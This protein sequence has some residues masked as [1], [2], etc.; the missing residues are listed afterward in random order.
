MF[1]FFFLF[2]ISILPRVD[3]LDLVFVFGF[4]LLLLEALKR[5]TIVYNNIFA[6]MASLI[7]F[8]MPFSILSFLNYGDYFGFIRLLK[9]ILLFLIVPSAFLVVGENTTFKIMPLFLLIMILILYFEYFNIFGARSIVGGIND[10]LF[11]GRDVSFRAKGL[12]AGYSAAG[13]SC[14]FIAIFSFYFT[15]KRK[16]SSSVG[17][18]LFFL[19]FFAT[20]FTGRTGIFIAILGVLSF[21]IL[22]CHRVFSAKIIGIFGGV[23]LLIITVLFYYWDSLDFTVIEIT[24]IRTFEL[25]LN[26]QNHGDFSSESSTQL[27]KTFGL[28]SE[29]F[30]IFFGNGLKPW[31]ELSIHLGAHQTDSGLFQTVFLYGVF[32]FVIYYMPII[33]IYFC[34]FK[35]R[36]DNVYRNYVL[37]IIPLAFIAEVKGHYIY[38]SLIF[39]LLFLPV[40]FRRA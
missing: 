4:F 18:P 7:L 17:W 40:F 2:S 30:D 15:L 24:F 37:I 21:S 39:V 27:A 19:A 11:V 3:Q 5:R 38:S 14:G 33:Y 31:S 25:F 22:E 28:P 13:V 23:I 26:Y 9:L 36:K 10:L 29:F 1:V 34:F 16:I 32:G 6:M 12:F 8:I 20:F 35:Q